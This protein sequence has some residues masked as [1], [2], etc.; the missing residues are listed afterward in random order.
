[1]ASVIKGKYGWDPVIRVCWITSSTQHDR[2]IWQISTQLFWILL[3][4][5]ITTLSASITI[6]HLYKHKFTFRVLRDPTLQYLPPTS[7]P[8]LVSAERQSDKSIGG[9]TLH[10]TSP[11]AIV[12]ASR[13]ASR[14]LTTQR[15]FR[16]V[17][18]RISIYPIVMVVLNLVITVADIR[19]SSRDGINNSAD[20]ALYAAYYILYGARGIFYAVIAFVDP[21]V[22]R[23]LILW[24]E[25][26]AGNTRDGVLP[27]L[28]NGPLAPP[29]AAGPT[30]TSER[31]RVD[32]L[33][34]IEVQT[35]TMRPCVSE[36]G[37]EHYLACDEESQ[38]RRMGTPLSRL[39]SGQDGRSAS[40]TSVHHV[41]SEPVPPI[42]GGVQ[43]TVPSD[44][45]A[46][47]LRS[48][49]E[50]KSGPGQDGQEDVSSV[51]DLVGCGKE[52]GEKKERGRAREAREAREDREIGKL[53][54]LGRRRER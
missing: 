11:K 50:N 42:L 35:G 6:T 15:G 30:G 36:L 10:P 12:E 1:M 29:S 45:R 5:T 41:S 7:G 47:N 31:M 48:G 18:L 9:T 54:K 32:D 44:N 46:G 3:A 8:A 28:D 52:Q 38:F 20:Y 34:G 26:Q 4:V 40:N 37:L 14:N 25:I 33:E 22:I 53:G 21:S 23:A 43:T 16:K 19:I 24:R 49:G 2:L 27:S 51:V 39:S 17:I 13:M